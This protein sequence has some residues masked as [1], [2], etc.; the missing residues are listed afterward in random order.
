[1][2]R[3]IDNGK[4]IIQRGIGHITISNAI[5]LLGTRPKNLQVTS[6]VAR[7]N[8]GFGMGLVFVTGTTKNM[9]VVT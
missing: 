3:A 6:G 9:Q 8:V 4:T 2:K 1:L 7:G 5:G